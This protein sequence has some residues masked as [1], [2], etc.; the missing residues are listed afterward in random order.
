MW[1]PTVAIDGDIIVSGDVTGVLKVWSMRTEPAPLNDKCV[2]TVKEH[3]GGIT[4][5]WVQGTRIVSSSSDKTIKVCAQLLVAACRVHACPY[6]SAHTLSAIKQARVIF[7]NVVLAGAPA[8]HNSDT[9]L[10]VR[11]L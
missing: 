7:L 6:D 1:I 5:L 4:G 3:T 8:F 2:A 10:A 9:H 11:W